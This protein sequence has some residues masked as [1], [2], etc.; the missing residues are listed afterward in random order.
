M[1]ALL[2]SSTLAA[3]EHAPGRAMAQPDLYLQI[4]S[5]I[6]P[7]DDVEGSSGEKVSLLRVREQCSQML[8]PPR[9]R[10]LETFDDLV[11]AT[12]PEASVHLASNTPWIADEFCTLRVVRTASGRRYVARL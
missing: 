2:Q 7:F 6:S 4:V 10:D 5:Q 1:P 9:R 3:K 12:P 8:S 11:P